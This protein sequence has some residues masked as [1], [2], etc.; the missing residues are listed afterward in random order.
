MKTTSITQIIVI[1]ASSVRSFQR[2]RGQHIT[3]GFMFFFPP[4]HHSYKK[5]ED[6]QILVIFY[7]QLLLVLLSQGKQ[8]TFM[9]FVV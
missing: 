3:I 4:Y 9:F 7:Q 5:I 8:H 1:F 6:N 2:Q